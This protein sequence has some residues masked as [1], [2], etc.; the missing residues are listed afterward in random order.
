MKRFGISSRPQHLGG[1]LSYQAERRPEAEFAIFIDQQRR[2]SFDEA[3]RTANRLPMDYTGRES[4]G[5][6]PCA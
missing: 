1:L 6:A 3:N 4:S 2:L 5:I